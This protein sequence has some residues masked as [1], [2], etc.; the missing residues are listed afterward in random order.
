MIIYE[1]NNCFSMRDNLFHCNKEAVNY[2]IN[3][4]YIRESVII[5]Y[6]SRGVC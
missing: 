2:L 4:G 6:N 3:R 1:R 5:N